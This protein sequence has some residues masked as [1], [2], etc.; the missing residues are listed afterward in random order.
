MNAAAKSPA[1]AELRAQ[2]RDRWRGLAPRERM[3]LAAGGLVIALFVA[4]SVLVAPALRVSRETPLEL[5]RLDAQLQ[6]MQGLAAEA[7][8]L[9]G[10]PPVTPAQAVEPLKAA[11]ARLGSKAT[12]A[13]QGERATLTLNG[14][15]GQALRDWLGEARTAARARPVDVQL[16]RG[17]AGYTGLVVVT[18]GNGGS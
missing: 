9:T 12:L 7:K 5:D 17:P 16:A 3:L 11:T 10:A 18:L 8:T 4:W 1:L 15:S 13:V 14:V 2:A 6:Q